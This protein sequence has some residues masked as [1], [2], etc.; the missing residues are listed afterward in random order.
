M[1]QVLISLLISSFAYSVLAQ[2]LHCEISY[3]NQVIFKNKVYV[4]EKNKKLS[5]GKSAIATAY[6]TVSEKNLYTVEAFLP[7]YEVRIY[8]QGG[9]ND[10]SESVTASLWG[11]ES[12]VDV[13]CRMAK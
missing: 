4:T 5:I 2:D 12:I 10:E 1:K 13:T 6:V 3:N 8:G 11:R 9:L 7:E